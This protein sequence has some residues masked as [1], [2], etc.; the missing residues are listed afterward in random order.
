[1]NGT[2]GL[3]GGNLHQRREWDPASIEKNWTVCIQQHTVHLS[4]YLPLCHVSYSRNLESFRFYTADGSNC[5]Q[6][7]LNYNR[8]Q[9]QVS[10]LIRRWSAAGVYRVSSTATYGGRTLTVRQRQPACCHRQSCRGISR[11]QSPRF[12]VRSSRPTP[13]ND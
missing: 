9:H 1:M 13:R 7:A 6:I 2:L 12:E 8:P 10:M 11:S 5:Q 4:R 3:S